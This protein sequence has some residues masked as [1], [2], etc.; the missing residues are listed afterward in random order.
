MSN[1][2][3]IANTALLS[4]TDFN[5]SANANVGYTYAVAAVNN[6]GESSNSNQ[7]TVSLSACSL[8]N[9]FNT[10]LKSDTEISCSNIQI[11]NVSISN[12]SNAT[13]NSSNSTT[14]NSEFSVELGSTL[15]IKSQ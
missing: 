4:Y 11:N 3:K 1:S 5:F 6:I 2:N 10:N 12:N 9:V 7:I 8:T 13:F 14:I 15:T